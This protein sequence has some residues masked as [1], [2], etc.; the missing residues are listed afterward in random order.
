MNKK[1]SDN[2]RLQHVEGEENMGITE[3]Y[4]S[5]SNLTSVVQIKTR[6]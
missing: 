3:G 4:N 1:K 2:T 5:L 6:Q